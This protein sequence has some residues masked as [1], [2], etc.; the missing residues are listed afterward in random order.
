MNRHRNSAILLRVALLF[1]CAALPAQ[2]RDPDAW[3]QR[4][5]WQHPAAVMDALHVTAGSTVAD[6]GAGEG[7]FTDRMAE[8]VGNTGK[9]YAV[10]VDPS[11]LR[12]LRELK[13]RRHLPQGRG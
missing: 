10:D 7:Y 1:S 8:R 13:D 11:A 3:P 4:D 6:V 2:Y 5:T 12:N 9:V